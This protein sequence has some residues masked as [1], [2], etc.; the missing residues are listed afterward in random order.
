VSFVVYCTVLAKA[1]VQSAM[2][3]GG[4]KLDASD[5]ADLARMHPGPTGKRRDVLAR[6]AAPR[7]LAGRRQPTAASTC[8]GTRWGRVRARPP[9]LL[10]FPRDQG[11]ASLEFSGRG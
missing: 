6:L 11:R 5:V 9:Q 2:D 10:T 7:M 4:L 8:A 1:V 3:T